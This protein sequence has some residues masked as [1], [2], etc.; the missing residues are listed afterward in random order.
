MNFRLQAVDELSVTAGDESDSR[1]ARTC[2]AR[3]QSDTESE[4]DQQHCPESTRREFPGRVA[5]HDEP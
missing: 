5:H 4:R 3:R 1:A 2:N